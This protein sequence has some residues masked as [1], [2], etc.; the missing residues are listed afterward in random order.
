MLDAVLF[1]NKGKG[2]PHKESLWKDFKT[3]SNKLMIWILLNSTAGKYMY[4]GE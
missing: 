1:L 3:H 2:Y 4:V